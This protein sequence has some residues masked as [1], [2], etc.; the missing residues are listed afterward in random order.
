[1]EEINIDW[2]LILLLSSFDCAFVTNMSPEKKKTIIIILSK[3]TTSNENTDDEKR[4]RKTGEKKSA[5]KIENKGTRICV[6]VS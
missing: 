2:R 1:M 3:R 5:R 4:A 6:R